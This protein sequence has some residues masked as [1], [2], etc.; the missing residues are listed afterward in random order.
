MLGVGHAAG[1]SGGRVR[2]DKILAGIGGGHRNLYEF[3]R[4]GIERSFDRHHR[5]Q[6]FPYPPEICRVVGKCAPEIVYEIALSGGADVVEHGPDCRCT[7]ATGT[8][9]RKKRQI[10]GLR[11]GA[12][13]GVVGVNMVAAIIIRA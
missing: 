9:L 8:G 2:L 3:A 12:I 7:L 4:Q 13:A 10:D 1:S 5:F 6:C 11:H